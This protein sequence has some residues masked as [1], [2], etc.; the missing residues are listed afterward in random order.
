MCE[1][2]SNVIERIS[3][4][5]SWHLT[6]LLNSDQ[7]VEVMDGEEDGKVVVSL[8]VPPSP[9]TASPNL[10]SNG[11]NVNNDSNESSDNKHRYEGGGNGV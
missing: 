11:I 5:F 4:C 7:I 1:T 3:F 6:E 2:E 10:A 8:V 9:T